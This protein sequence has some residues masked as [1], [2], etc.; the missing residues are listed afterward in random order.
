MLNDD[1]LQQLEEF[2]TIWEEET[3]FEDGEDSKSS[4][5]QE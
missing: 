2:T 1:L 4:A 5:I 3:G